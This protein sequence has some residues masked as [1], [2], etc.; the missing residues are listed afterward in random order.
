MTTD[1]SCSNFETYNMAGESP[2]KGYTLYTAGTPNGDLNRL[3]YRIIFLIAQFVQKIVTTAENGFCRAVKKSRCTGWKPSI[4]LE[5]LGIPY[6]VRKISL[7]DNEQKQDW[8]LKINPN[9]R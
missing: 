3:Y 4:T 9:G 2:R 7:S 8:F 1:S 5:E 6:D